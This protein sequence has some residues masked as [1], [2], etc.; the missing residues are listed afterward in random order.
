MAKLPLALPTGTTI[1]RDGQDANARLVNAYVEEVGSE[2]KSAYAVYA[3]PGLTRFDSASYTG[4]ARGMIELNSNALI[5]FL[6]N[7]IVQFDQ[8]GVDTVLGTL[9]GSGQ[10]HLARNRASTPEIGIV[11]GSG[12]YYIL[13]G[14]TISQI[15][16]TD[17]PTPNSI[18]YLKGVFIYGIKDGRIFCSDLEDGTA[19]QADAFGTARSDSSDL[20]TVVSHAGFLYVFKAKGAEIW[21]ADPSLAAENF[22]FSPVQQDIDIGCLAPHSVAELQRGLVW[23]DDDGI[24]RYGRDGGAQRISNHTVEREIASLSNSQRQ[25]IEGFKYVFHGHEIY[26]L[27]SASWSYEYDATTL[28]WYQRKSYG[29]SRWQA[30]GCEAFN[31]AY[32]VGNIVDGKL[33]QIDA[34][35]HTEGDDNL[36]ME[37][38]CPQS[39]RFPE[40]MVADSVYLDVIAGVGSASGG[41]HATDPQVMIDYS[42]DGGAVFEGQ[43]EEPLGKIGERK[44]RVK[45]DKWGLVEEQGR[46]WRF[47]A[48]APVLRGMMHAFV[49][50]RPLP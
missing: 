45:S 38:W 8:G 5:A 18:T 49:A 3:A 42:D 39:H 2:G 31:G 50:A 26:V 24:V 29:L 46:I 13:S 25:A 16:D 35:S 41:D 40:R 9:V 21:Q 11:T 43:R 10:L 14:G 33:Y 4:T 22:F 1:G 6:G 48:S 27:T 47:S 19:I 17:L 7:Q 12:Q 37:I 15:N 20:R 23:V 30:T 28:K 34:D 32:V 36:V 44:R